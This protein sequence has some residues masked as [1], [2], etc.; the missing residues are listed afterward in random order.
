M[1]DLTIII[2]FNIIISKIYYSLID[3]KA[4]AD[5]NNLPYL[6]NLHWIEVLI[7]LPPLLYH[8]TCEITMN[9]QSIGKKIFGIKVI[10]ENG[11]RP[12]FSQLLIRWLLRLA[13]FGFSFFMGGLFSVL[14]SKKDQRLGDMAAGTLVINMRT[15]SDLNE[16]VFV[17]L[18]EN[19]KPKFANALLLSDRDM[20]IIKTILDTKSFSSKESMAT[21]AS[22][23]ISAVLNITGYMP[24]VELL[25]TVL[26]DYNYLSGQR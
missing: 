2:T 21:R 22:E 17:E 5:D 14:L 18:N 24:P 26:K 3:T 1:T 7:F 20:N 4:A 23:K 12:A 9:G 6:Y 8:L 10:N 13:D 15:K 19:Y 11:G 16:T 25:E